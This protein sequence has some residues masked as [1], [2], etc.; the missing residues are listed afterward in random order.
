M[1]N[2]QFHIGE[3]IADPHSS[4]YEYDKRNNFQITVKTYTDF[5]DRQE[6]QVIPFNNNI[7]QIPLVGEHVLLIKGLSAENNAETIYPKWYYLA[8]FSLNS[9]V[10]ANLLP[11]VAPSNVPYTPK[12]SFAEQEVSLLQAYEG[13]TLVEGRFGNSIRIGS[14]IKGGVYSIQPSWSGNVSADPI[15]ILSNGKSYKKDSYI[16]ESIQDDKSSVYLTST[17]KISISLGDTSNKN[18]LSCYLPGETQFDK[19]QFIGTGDRV[20]LKAKTDIAIID[21]PKAIILNTTGEIK[22][23]SDT[24]DQSMVHGDVLLTVLQ[25]ILNQLNKPIQ[26]GTMTGTFLDRSSIASAQLDLQNLLSHK[27]YINK[28]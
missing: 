12:T 22:L 25:K 27:Y 2:V 11:G 24:A 19:S 8:S 6:L 20:I 10:N 3:V 5:Y 13:D 18:P 16:V 26:C 1:D 21:S 23:G 28:T 15:I 7:K 14:T 17:Q 4:T 9:N